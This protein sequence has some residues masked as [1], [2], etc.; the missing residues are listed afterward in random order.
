[1]KITLL[2]F[3]VPNKVMERILSNDSNMPIQTHKFAWSIVRSLVKNNVEVDLIS[4]EPVTN[5]PRNQTII[6]KKS[7]F[8][9]EYANGIT[10]PF[11]NIIGLKHLTRLISTL[12]YGMPRIIRENSDIILIHGVHSPY[13]LASLIFKKLMKK[14]IV[15][16]LTDPPSQCY[17]TDSYLSILLKKLDKVLIKECLKKFD[18][19]ISLTNWLAKDFA[20]AI[21]SIIIEGI[22]DQSFE[23]DFDISNNAYDKENLSRSDCLHIVYAGG[24]E[25][26]YGAKILI[27]GF[28]QLKNDNLKLSIFGKGNYVPEIINASQKDCRI[29]YG[30][31]QSNSKLLSYLNSA[32]I[33]INPR[34]SNQDFVKYSFPSKIL[35]YMQTGVP[36]LTTNLPGIPKDYH[37]YLYFIE[38]ETA[39][40]IAASINNLLMLSPDELIEKGEAA[41]GFV[42]KFKNELVQG[43]KITSFFNKLLN[44]KDT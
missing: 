28:M 6:F 12:L 5:Y 44:N 43:N 15:V 42:N 27:D 40:G 4:S 13:L 11:I 8:K 2:G 1:M 16:I 36:V 38:H 18:G 33:L 32:D 9:T 41:K 29:F 37:P 23:L 20:S 34:P 17:K 30:G 3:T 31:F 10:L 7:E 39:Q 21:P 35:Q 25:E 14:K 24:L 26:S 19:N 22:N